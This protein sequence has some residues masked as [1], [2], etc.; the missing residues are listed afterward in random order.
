MAELSGTGST[1]HLADLVDLSA[2]Q[3]GP[4]PAEVLGVARVSA[5]GTH[6]YFVAKGQ[7]TSIANGFG[8]QPQIGLPNLYVYDVPTHQLTYVTTLAE[9][10]E[11]IWS[12]EGAGPFQATPDGQ[13]AV[14]AS[15]GDL[16]PDD[17]ST[18]AQVFRYDAGTG[19]LVRVSVGQGGFNDNGNTDVYPAELPRL[20]MFGAASVGLAISD[21]GSYVVFQSANGLT[22]DALNG[23]VTSYEYEENKEPRTGTFLPNN[24]YEYHDGRVSL[25]SDG[26][27]VTATQRESSVRLIGLSSSG[28]DIYLQTAD[29]LV[30]Q[31]TDSLRDIY[32]ARVDGG[33][34]ARTVG[35]VCVTQC[36]GA[37]PPPPTDPS[38]ASAA[39]SGPGDV[40]PHHPKPRG[41]KRHHKKRHKKHRGQHSRQ[42]DTRD[43]SNTLTGGQR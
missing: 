6:V 41:H 19:Q 33:F 7:L 9:A 26:A 11:S 1:A 13:F 30:T 8:A 25:V 24:V 10:D 34:P 28:R 4:Q 42:R 17:T 21:D 18:A 16:T 32:D 43:R 22:P 14:F 39:F 36:Q 5:D 12:V 15:S 3:L 35:P 27:D 38:P 37:G 40:K 29:Q 2:D 31:D 20:T 23:Q